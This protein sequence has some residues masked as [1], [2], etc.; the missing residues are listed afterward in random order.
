MSCLDP[1]KGLV[2]WDHSHSIYR[3]QGSSRIPERSLDEG[4]VLMVCQK[5]QALNQTNNFPSRAVWMKGYVV[6][7]TAAPKAIRTN[8]YVR[9][10]WERQRS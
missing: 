9:E 7:H 3:T 8:E 2:L 10:R 5:S 4:P 6:C 1:V